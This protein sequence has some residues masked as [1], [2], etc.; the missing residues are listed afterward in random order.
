MRAHREDRTDRQPNFRWQLHF[1]RPNAY[2][3]IYNSQ[4]KWDKDRQFYRAFDMDESFFTQSDYLKWKHGRGLV[5]NMF[6][7]RAVLELQHVVRARVRVHLIRSGHSHLLGCFASWIVSVTCSK[8][9]MPPVSPLHARL[10]SRVLSIRPVTGKSS[11]LY[12]G[13]QCFSADT[14]TSF[15]FSTSFDQMSFPDFRGDL[16]EGIDIAMP[17]VTF[18]KFSAFFVWLIHN[19]PNWLLRVASPRLNGVVLFREVGL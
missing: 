15:L 8:N 7:K 19:A 5:S 10:L 1:A 14:I 2:N 18:A 11:N 4:N 9:T 13:F 12:L 16:I 17:T 3:E 6:S